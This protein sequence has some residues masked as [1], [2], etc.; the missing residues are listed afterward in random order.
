MRKYRH[1]HSPLGIS[2]EADEALLATRVGIGHDE[3]TR[4][5]ESAASAKRTL[6]FLRFCCRLGRV[7]LVPV[8]GADGMYICTPPSS[9]A[10]DSCAN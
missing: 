9:T 4:V 5:L 8:H 10:P 7:P 6:C 2:A 1:K 3:R